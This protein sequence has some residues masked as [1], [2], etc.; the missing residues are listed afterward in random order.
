MRDG[1]SSGTP[2]TRRLKQPTRTAGSGH[3]SRASSAPWREGPAPF[4]FGFAPGG[5]YRAVDVAADAVRSYRTVSPL[6]PLP[7]TP[8]QGRPRCGG[9]LLSV[10]LSLGS[11]PP[12]VIRHRWSMEPGLFLPGDPSLARRWCG[13]KRPGF[14]SGHPTD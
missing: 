1:H 12:E 9:G 8:S 11:R 7:R 14:R 10:A 13:S 5:V 4:L 3:R 2:V 6:P